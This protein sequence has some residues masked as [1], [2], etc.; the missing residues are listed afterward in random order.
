M[1]HTFASF[2]LAGGMSVQDL[3]DMIGTSLEMIDQT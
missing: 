1:R 2:G 3:K